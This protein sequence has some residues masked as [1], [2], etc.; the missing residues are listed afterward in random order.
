[1]K[2]YTTG[3]LNRHQVTIRFPQMLTNLVIAGNVFLVIIKTITP[4]LN[5]LL[6][7]MLMVLVTVSFVNQA[8]K[9]VAIVA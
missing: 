9:K 3:L 1:M 6:M 8:I 5:Y 7:P 2:V 4:V